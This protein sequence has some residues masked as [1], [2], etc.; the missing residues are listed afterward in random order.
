MHLVGRRYGSTPEDDAR[1]IVKL[2]ERLSAERSQSDPAFR[3]LLWIPPGLG[4]ADLEISDD[5]QKTFI[6]D[7][8]T[9]VMPGAEVLQTSIEDLKTRIMEKLNLQP[10]RSSRDVQPSSRFILFASTWTALQ[11]VR[12]RSTSSN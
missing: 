2:Q 9:K 4:N 8:Q 7:L 1:S 12:S 11:Y 5:R 10:A 6:A 3:R